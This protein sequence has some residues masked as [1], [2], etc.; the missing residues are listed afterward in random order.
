MIR[1]NELNAT[2]NLGL[3]LER[4]ITAPLICD[5][6]KQDH[7]VI[8]SKHHN[9]IVGIVAANSAYRAALQR[10]QALSKG[11]ASAM[12]VTRGQPLAIGLGDASAAEVG[13]RLHHTY[14]VPYL[15]GSSLKGLTRRAAL[16]FG[17]EEGSEHWQVLFGHSPEG[18][19][20][21]GSR[22][23]PVFWDG[24]WVPVGQT[25]K[26]H[27]DVVTPHHQE[28]YSSQGK[29]PPTDFDAP[30]PVSFV[31]VPV[32]WKFL[33]TVSC[34]EAPEWADL[35][36]KILLYGLSNLGLG[37]KTNSGYGRFE[38]EEAH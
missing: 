11:Y 21:G 8:A 9:A 10:W 38:Y 17:L 14:G 6:G 32:G 12:V 30:I 31:T 19:D 24:W 27:L 5:Q 33:V 18:Q 25:Q 7:Q 35:A 16:D 4:G 29:K 22:G 36:L 37:A 23:Y 20:A 3:A 26:L 34:V 13:L 2:Q 1:E 15:P 28:Y